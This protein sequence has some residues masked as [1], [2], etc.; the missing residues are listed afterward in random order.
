MRNLLGDIAS[1]SGW[2][3]SKFS[4]AV[5]LIVAC[6][7]SGCAAVTE[8]ANSTA[9]S[10]PHKGS[11]LT[12]T[13][14]SLP[15][16]QLA[17]SYSAVLSATGGTSPYRWSLKSGSLPAGLTLNSGGQISGLPAQ[18]GT[19]SFT[20]QV[21]D[22]SSPRQTASQLLNVTITAV[23]APS[24]TPVSITTTY[25]PTG[26]IGAAY[27]AT[28]AASGGTPPYSWAIGSGVLPPG[29]SLNSSTGQISGTPTLSSTASVIVHVTDSS[30]TPQT[31][32]QTLTITVTA[33]S[34]PL[35]ITTSS[36]VSAH[37]GTA[38]SA[39]LAASGGTTPYTWSI[40]GGTLPAGLTLNSSGQISGTP[41][42]SGSLSFTAKVADSTTPTPLTA[43][44]V[45]SITVTA[46]VTPVQITTTSFPA[47][48][49]AVV[50]STMLG[51]TGGAAPYSWSISSGG[52]PAGLTISAATGTISGTPTAAGSFSFT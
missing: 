14:N 19:Y 6:L 44:K 43:A 21:Q 28:M 50:Y 3:H 45:F 47:G 31:A 24:V 26:Y 41:S 37:Q 13:T 18:T 33:A 35:S 7:Y 27:A 16:A 48:Q 46:A 32:S 20:A 30:Y 11:T 2:P 15:P 36:I 34:T 12:V 10:K 38:Y 51:A 22:S 25:L 49:V 8:T 5:A 39:T 40:E 29:L 17:S 42:V 9:T 1:S 23:N 52:L 4:L